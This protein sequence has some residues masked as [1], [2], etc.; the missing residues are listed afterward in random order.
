MISADDDHETGT[1]VYTQ[2]PTMCSITSAQ[3]PSSYH[4]LRGNTT[5]KN[6]ANT[7]QE[8]SLIS[9]ARLLLCFGM[10]ACLWPGAAAFA[11]WYLLLV[12]LCA[13]RLVIHPPVRTCWRIQLLSPS[14]FLALVYGWPWPWVCHTNWPSREWKRWPEQ[15]VSDGMPWNRRT[16]S[17]QLE[18][19]DL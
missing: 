4:V 19:P 15:L 13:G 7:K 14:N 2:A 5:R 3:V 16:E 8:M 9:I 12:R 10:H 17:V 11:T 1:H 18:P 6:S